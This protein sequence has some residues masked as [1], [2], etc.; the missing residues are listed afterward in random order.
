MLAETIAHTRSIVCYVHLKYSRTY[1]PGH[2]P[3]PGLLRLL[4]MHTQS[5]LES[6]IGDTAN[7]PMY[8][9]QVFIYIT[10]RSLKS[11]IQDDY[12]RALLERNT[13]SKNAAVV[14]QERRSAT[15]FV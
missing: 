8:R 9:A 13:S 7:S 2:H 1:V 6:V 10:L 3:S 14:A 5:I 11:Q 12:N 15:T 4:L